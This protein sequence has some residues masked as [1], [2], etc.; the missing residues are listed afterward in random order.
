MLSHKWRLFTCLIFGFL[1]VTITPVRADNCS[2][3]TDCYQY[4]WIAVIAILGL[5]LL[6]YFWP[7]IWPLLL[8]LG[9]ALG[10]MILRA[11]RSRIAR[12]IGNT[13]RNLTRG[14]RATRG[15]QRQ[16]RAH[17]QKLRNYRR[18]PDKFDNKG[19]LKNA[20][21]DAVRKNIIE[22]RIRHLEREIKAFEDAIKRI[23][24]GG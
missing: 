11:G 16:I 18:N 4:I 12:G 3:L 14:N 24:K 13:I 5:L 7:V 21:N 20:P 22:K 15:L 8:R 23:D 1:F 9:P 2:G 17:R 19:F 6:W 10:R